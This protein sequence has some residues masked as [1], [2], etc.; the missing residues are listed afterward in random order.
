VIRFRNDVVDV[1]PLAAARQHE[2]TWRLNRERRCD[3]RTQRRA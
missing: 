3:A 1:E 2:Y